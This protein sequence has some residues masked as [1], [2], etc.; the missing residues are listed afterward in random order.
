MA[1]IIARRRKD[2]TCSYRA[3]TRTMRGNPV[4]H[5]AARTFHDNGMAQ[6]WARALRGVELLIDDADFAAYKAHKQAV[7]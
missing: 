7:K 5:R 1:T 3:S 2:G 6:Q 4:L